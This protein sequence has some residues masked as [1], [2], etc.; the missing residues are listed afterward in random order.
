MHKGINRG[1]WIRLLDF[2][3]VMLTLGIAVAMCMSYLATFVDPNSYWMFAFFGLAA[4]FLFVAN[5][6]MLLFWVVR[7]R[8]W[9]AVPAFVFLIGIGYIGDFVQPHFAKEYNN[10]QATADEMTIMTYNVHGFYQFR[11]AQNYVSTLDSITKYV[12]L[13]NPDIVCFQEFQLF[14]ARDSSLLSSRMGGWPYVQFSYVVN[15]PSHKWGLAVFSKY[16]LANFHPIRFENQQNS[17]MSV[18]VMPAKGDTVRLFNCHLQTTQ[19]N[20]VSPDGLRAL[21][22]HQDAGLIIR[23]IGST[24]RE[25]FKLRAQQVDTVAQLISQTHLPVVVVGDFN[26]TPLSYTYHTMRG[27]LTDSFCEKGS[28][29]E[30]TYK[31][32]MR[33]F[34]IDY[35]L[36][37]DHLKATFHTSPTTPWS[38]HNPVITRLKFDK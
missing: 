18:D 3:L 25:N 24:L 34:R 9:L 13:Q 23:N 10:E 22:N 1:F 36:H 29:Y 27:E 28:G 4:P 30:Y 12:N 35:I 2:F 37:S 21:Y 6:V 38:D 16:P 17:S 8:M 15:S 33:L 31:P 32:L 14:N 20:Q 5:G 11:S 7:M 19:F 26:D